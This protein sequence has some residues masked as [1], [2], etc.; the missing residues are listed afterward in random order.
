MNLIAIDM[1]VFEAAMPE[2][3]VCTH[4]CQSIMLEHHGCLRDI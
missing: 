2:Y 3:L 4:V 1:K